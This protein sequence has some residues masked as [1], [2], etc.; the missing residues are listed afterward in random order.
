MDVHRRARSSFKDSAASV[1]PVLS[2]IA[3]RLVSP[4]LCS[5]LKSRGSRALSLTVES[6]RIQGRSKSILTAS[7]PVLW[8]SSAWR[9]TIDALTSRNLTERPVKAAIMSISSSR[10]IISCLFHAPLPSAS[11]FTF[12]STRSIRGCR[13]RAPAGCPDQGSGPQ[14]RALLRT[15]QCLGPRY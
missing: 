1:F 4:A 10:Y 7:P 2:R 6:I 5:S 11:Y 12:Q 15:H 8:R 13:R 9:P 3:L 14:S